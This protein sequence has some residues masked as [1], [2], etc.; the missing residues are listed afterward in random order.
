MIGSVYVK[1]SSICF[2]ESH[3]D[4]NDSFGQIQKRAFL[5][6]FWLPKRPENTG[7]IYV[8]STCFKRIRKA[9]NSGDVRFRSMRA[10]RVNLKSLKGTSFPREQSADCDGEQ[11]SVS[12]VKIHSAGQGNL[13]P[14]SNSGGLQDTFS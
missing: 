2:S 14:L 9:A 13:N 10:D 12:G 5:V 8:I 1:R 11:S 4:L 3:C 6:P 7:M